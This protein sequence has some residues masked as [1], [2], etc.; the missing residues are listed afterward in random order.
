MIVYIIYVRIVLIHLFI[1]SFND[2]KDDPGTW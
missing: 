2:T 1:Y